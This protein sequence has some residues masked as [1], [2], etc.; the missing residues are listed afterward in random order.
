MKKKINIK[1]FTDYICPWCYLG[2]AVVKNLQD[3]Y[4][5]DIDHIGFELHPDTKPEGND[6]QAQ[7]PGI[8]GMYDRIRARGRRY[9][10]SFAHLTVLPNSREAL[11]VGEYAKQTG[12]S[13]AYVKAMWEAYFTEGKNIGE[14][15]VVVDTARKVGITE[16][17]VDEALRNAEYARRLERN[18]QEGMR[19][20]VSSVP[21]F[22]I[23]EQV[24]VVG[25]Q[26]EDV[27]R[28]VF[29]KLSAAGGE[30]DAGCGN[31]ACRLG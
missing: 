24:A 22:I 17:E 2:D 18:M 4:D 28:D 31:G 25:A 16:A 30:E 12:K 3:E 15:R 26:T 29:E 6:L 1:L 27:F 13:E 21:T 10:L 7:F 19:Y 14:H 8:D 9:G 20:G 5:I 23:D 11:L